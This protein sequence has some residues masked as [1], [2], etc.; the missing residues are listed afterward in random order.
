ME[1]EK[2]QVMDKL[3]IEIFKHRFKYHVRFRQQKLK[4]C[5]MLALVKDNYESNK[6]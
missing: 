3:F 1:K 2:F 5:K 4:S 6:P